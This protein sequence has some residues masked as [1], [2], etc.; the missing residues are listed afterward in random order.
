MSVQFFAY[1]F[2]VLLF[3]M[4]IRILLRKQDF[5][6]RKLFLPWSI[7]LFVMATVS[8]GCETYRFIAK[9]VVGFH[10][11][12]TQDTSGLEEY[13][14]RDIPR[15]VT[16]GFFFAW[17]ILMNATADC[18]LMYRCYVI[19]GSQ[20]RVVIIPF[21]A[22]LTF[23]VMGFVGVVMYGIGKRNQLVPSNLDLVVKGDM[24]ERVYLIGSA[25]VNLLLTLLTAARIWWIT[26]EA[27]ALMGR[28]VS[29]R[30]QT[31]IAII[32]ESGILFP[33]FAFLHIA[34]TETSDIVYVPVNFLPTAAQMGAIAPTL[35][36]VRATTGA[37][38]DS[39]QTAFSTIHFEAGGSALVLSE[40]RPKT[41]SKLE[42]GLGSSASTKY[43][44]AQV[45]PIPER[46]D[47][48]FEWSKE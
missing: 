33:V 23:S 8:V 41:P 40:T 1:G 21:L 43:G 24:L 7:A 25:S 3:G 44:S 9:T 47:R 15:N 10:A 11:V 18:I 29:K 32:L 6:N 12:K 30:Y 39:V 16:D 4:C 31:V 20:K 45:P 22:A 14:T 48:H 19:W 5:A 34:L 42:A 38:V 26:K 36:I 37:S 46:L 13:Y 2:Y 35:I 27:R 28:P 17:F